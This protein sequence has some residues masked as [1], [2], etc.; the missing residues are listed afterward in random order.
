MKR[1]IYLFLLYF[2]KPIFILGI[3]LT[4]LSS[5]WLKLIKTLGTGMFTD[6][7]FM[8]LGIL[9]IIDDYYQPLI[10]P[11]K[12]LKKSLRN[13]RDLKCIDFNVN[14]QLSLLDKFNYN[15]E[16]LKFP[17]EKNKEN[18]FFF[19]N[20]MYSSGDAEY[21]Y[22]M[23]RYFKPKR[24]I[25]I[26]CGYST[27]MASNAIAKNKLED[28][29]YTCNHICIE[30]FERLWINKLNIEL[31]REKVEDIDKDFF[32]K[33]EAN[34]ILF[35]DSSHIIRPQGDV[36]FEYMEILPYLNSGVLV[37]THDIFSPKDYPDRWIYEEHLL[38]NEQYLLEAF[39]SFNSDFKI[40]GALNYLAHNHQKELAQKCPFYANKQGY[41]ENKSEPRAFWFVRK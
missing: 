24:F 23:I 32:K 40:I 12:Y 36:L 7:I 11:K 30:P 35:I 8:R 6:K 28:P 16:L 15:E 21:L 29:D 1:Y 25:E 2:R 33:L 10:N 37:H 31:I 26:G 18:E 38:W 19:N 34:D 17:F 41:E 14:E 27:L 13:D 3:P 5:V 39:L 20:N 22:N 4:F 9:P